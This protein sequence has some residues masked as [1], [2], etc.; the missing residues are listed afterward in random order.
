MIILFFT[1]PWKLCN[2]LWLDPT[3]VHLTLYTTVFRGN[4]RLISAGVTVENLLHQLHCLLSYRVSAPSGDWKWERTPLY[5]DPSDSSNLRKGSRRTWPI[6]GERSGSG[7]GHA[8]RLHPLRCKAN[9]ACITLGFVQRR[10]GGACWRCQGRSGAAVQMEPNLQFWI[11][12]R[13]VLRVW[14]LGAGGWADQQDL[15]RLP[16]VIMTFLSEIL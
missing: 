13:Q 7:A 3:R 1:A 10:G 2:W 4:V 12:E 15:D 11:S 16:C 14:V 8:D 6:A 5:P 9:G